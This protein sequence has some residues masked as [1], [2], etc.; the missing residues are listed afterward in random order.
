MADTIPPDT[1]SAGSGNP[2]VDMD[3]VADVLS[4]LTGVSPGSNLTP[5]AVPLVAASLAMNTVTGATTSPLTVSGSSAAGQLVYIEQ[6]SST[7]HALTVNL[8]GTGGAAQS[9]LNVVSANSAFSAAEISGT[10]TAH[11]TLKMT[12]HGYAAGSDSGAS[13]LSVDLQTTVGGSTGTQAQGLFITSTTD[14]IPG[15]NAINV[16]YNSQDWFV[17]KGNVGTGNGIVG[18]GVAT[19]HTPAGMLEIAQKDT[20]T[21]G[22][23]MSALASGADMVELKDSGGNLRFQV[24][25]A[26]NL[27]TRATT[28]ISTNCQIGSTTAA[29]S[30]GGNGCIGIS[31]AS[32]NPTGNPT[33]GG[34][35]Y[36][37]AGALFWLGTSGAATQIAAA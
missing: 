9:A 24:N 10:E 29:V 28:L 2:P 14:S 30:G 7:D 16:R 11:G 12:H 22:L 6:D 20:T 15:G 17:V 37:S 35:L 34:V 8:A 26:G 36:A 25:N 19:G 3:D 4:L 21:V 1:R 32:T 5:G 33:G 31:N 27:I 13:A 23:Y 18:I